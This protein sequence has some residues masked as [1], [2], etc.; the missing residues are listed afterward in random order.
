[1]VNHKVSH[2]KR[3]KEYRLHQVLLSAWKHPGLQYMRD[4]RDPHVEVVR[5]K[6][7]DLEVPSNE[8]SQSLPTTKHPCMVA[9]HVALLHLS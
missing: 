8:S 1:M 9:Y 5:L 3:K 2:L 6:G 4:D 7:Q